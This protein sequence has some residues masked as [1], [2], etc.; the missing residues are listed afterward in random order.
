M[1]TNLTQLLRQIAIRI[2]H[3]Y[4]LK[5]PFLSAVLGCMCLIS[6]VYALDISILKIE[7]PKPSYTIL[8]NSNGA[9]GQMDPVT[10]LCGESYTIPTIYDSENLN[11]PYFV[12]PGYHFTPDS[13]ELGGDY[14]WWQYDLNM[15][16]RGI[17]H[18][19]DAI[20]EEDLAV[21]DDF[22]V[23]YAH[24]IPNKYTV[25]YN[26]NIPTLNV[27]T[28]DET[29]S[30]YTATYGEPFNLSEQVYIQPYMYQIGWSTQALGGIGADFYSL[31]AQCVNLTQ[32][33]DAKVPLYAQ[34]MPKKTLVLYRANSGTG[35]EMP[36]NTYS[37]TSEGLTLAANT[38][39]RQGYKF[40]GWDTN[41]Y[42]DSP[43]YTL[44]N[45]VISIDTLQNLVKN[46]NESW[47]EFYAIWAPI[48]YTIIFNNGEK[49]TTGDLPQNIS[50]TYDKSFTLP[51]KGEDLLCSGY[52][53]EGWSRN[54]DGSNPYLPHATLF[55]LTD[56]DNNTIT[57]YPSWKPI[58]YCVSFSPNL[59][60]GSMA[61]T[62]PYLYDKEYN[63]PPVD[64]SYK[65]EGFSFTGWSLNQ[66]AVA[67]DYEDGATV[68]NLT[69]K[70]Y[71]VATLYA[72]W[73]VKE[74]T[75]T[76]VN[77]NGD[78]N[79]GISM[80]TQKVV[81]N[82]YTSL[83]K[84]LFSKTGYRFNGWGLNSDLNGI[85]K[86]DDQEY[87]THVEQDT[88]LYTRWLVNIYSVNYLLASADEDEGQSQMEE[89]YFYYNQPE[90]LHPCTYTKVGHHF[91]HWEYTR[92]DGT[93]KTYSTETLFDAPP[94]GHMDEINVFA[95]W[96]PNDYT[97]RFSPGDD[98][99]G[100]EPSGNMPRM[101]YYYGQT[102]ED[103]S[104]V[105][106]PPI[107]F[108]PQDG[109]VFEGWRDSKN[110]NAPLLA[111][112]ADASAFIV[113]TN[114]IIDLEAQWRPITYT[115]Q[116]DAN[117]GESVSPFPES[118][119]ATYDSSSTLP[120]SPYSEPKTSGK[121]GYAFGGWCQSSNGTGEI[122]DA[123]EIGTFN[124]TTT[125]SAT[126]TLYVHWIPNVYTVIYDR[127][128]GSGS[129]MPNQS[130]TY[131]KPDTLHANSYTKLGYSF[132]GWECR[133]DPANPITYQDQAPV[134]NLT[135]E[136]EGEVT[137]YATWTPIHFLIR[138]DTNGGVGFRDDVKVDYDTEHSVE[139]NLFTFENHHFM[140]VWYCPGNGLNYSV[141]T[142]IRN[143]TSIMQPSGEPKVFILKAQWQGNVYNVYF[144]PGE[145]GQ[146][147]MSLQAFTYNISQKLKPS[148]FVRTGYHQ[149]SMKAWLSNA[150]ETYGNEQEVL[151][152]PRDPNDI[153]R[154]TL[155]A[156][157]SPNTFTIRFVSNGA[158][159]G[160]MLDMTSLIYGDEETTL[161][162]NAFTK[163]HSRFSGWSLAGG[164]IISDEALIADVYNKL[165]PKHNDTITLTAIWS[166]S[167]YEV[168]FDKNDSVNYPV[169]G[170]NMKNQG[171]TYGIVQ[172]LT[173][174]LYKRTGFTF[175]NWKDSNDTSYAD[176]VSVSN[177]ADTD[178]AIVAFKAQWRAHTY[179]VLFD[180]ARP[181]N[182][183]DDIDRSQ[184]F[185]YDDV[186]PKELT[187]YPISC[188]GFDFNQ[189]ENVTEGDGRGT[190]Y[191]NAQSITKHLSTKDNAT[192]T[193]KAHW[194]PK[195]YIIRFDSNNKVAT[196]TMRDQNFVYNYTSTLPPN[197]YTLTDHDFAGWSTQS[198]DITFRYVD[199]QLIHPLITDESMVDPNV[200]MLY[201]IWKRS[202]CTV[203]FHP[204]GGIFAQ[205][206]DVSGI[207]RFSA[208][209]DRLPVITRTGYTF[210][211]WR[212]SYRQ[213]EG[214]QSA[215]KN[216]E[217]LSDRD[218]TLYATWQSTSFP[219][220]TEFPY[221]S[222][223]ILDDD[224]NPWASWL[225]ESLTS[226][227]ESSRT[228]D[229]YSGQ[230]QP[231]NLYLPDRIEDDP[232]EKLADYSFYSSD[233]PHYMINT[234]EHIT[235]PLFTRSI[236]EQTFA[237]N[238]KLKTITF[239]EL[240]DYANGI[241]G[242]LEIGEKAFAANRALTTVTFP[243]GLIS[244]G[245]EAFRECT[246]LK[247]IYFSGS[248]P[249]FGSNVFANIISDIT[250]YYPQ[251]QYTGYYDWMIHTEDTGRF[252]L[253]SW[254]P[255][256]PSMGS[257]MKAPSQISI[258]NLLHME[259]PPST[260]DTCTQSNAFEVSLLLTLD[261]STSNTW[262]E[263]QCQ[264]N[265]QDSDIRIA[266]KSSLDQSLSWTYM[267]PQSISYIPEQGVLLV[268]VSLPKEQSGF[269][270][271]TIR[272][273][274]EDGEIEK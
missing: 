259:S 230:K 59:G 61:A 20:V 192:V 28:L 209:Y 104:S 36:S 76:F 223:S 31:N 120:S 45:Q 188:T 140:D 151:N 108:I 221:G 94:T 242:T 271:V 3:T 205:A 98:T 64:P 159:N 43:I 40:M 183:P 50:C 200:I 4:R 51:A 93:V 88:S 273:E 133:N 95:V 263:T 124:F 212:S 208:G 196:G 109:Y 239:T 24:W 26:S 70:L 130:F 180:S 101:N 253:K 198:T 68:K 141:G 46:Q 34:W 246:A 73:Q 112:Q 248:V 203:T 25:E 80:P 17:L 254:N 182:K 71:G 167:T 216:G 74:V 78:T 231:Q 54:S 47:L 21:E 201:T 29:I 144:D 165:T 187:S 117:G 267:T 269:L 131:D 265:P 79:S 186:M 219:G 191:D 35:N 163:T 49:S 161:S 235:T 207:Y 7:M 228:I 206:S 156:Q 243:R 53:F 99:S 100:R 173:P 96:T 213:V 18:R 122:Y 42:A 264:Q 153:D 214:T 84:N 91:I 38:Y 226:W 9:S 6:H 184:N 225:K 58:T 164:S 266:Y 147:S 132:N 149:D 245:D 125:Q 222:N 90:L 220:I 75:L 148:S 39:T 135:A 67:S 137:L 69:V 110:P 229:I 2:R 193:L 66:N 172:A 145:D 136:D 86:Y 14:G 41:P 150:L 138:Y 171:F 217:L 119:S 115:I 12:N 77:S 268:I 218:H 72:V 249:T 55:N 179:T 37:H 82:E 258:I 176:N 170:D 250:V 139:G 27:S 155:T 10:V 81:Y 142:P 121:L 157:W 202:E 126:V 134:S 234:F 204:Q 107:A 11:Q 233:Q 160:T 123:G 15:G 257:S 22:V 32:E 211:G 238:Y 8:F 85:V 260:L 63:L 105:K 210:T 65:R 127:G 16:E 241:D 62:E 162:P 236:G 57:F 146:G 190:F 237:Y 33:K 174:N 168:R 197:T 261:G 1:F 113:S 83:S 13:S 118:I 103:G 114:S 56:I 251:G 92:L 195:E 154:V 185:S 48:E 44:A 128:S 256:N 129:S 194:T 5:V 227:T 215:I 143:L 199:E 178:G 60:I 175:I 270:K 252:T 158:D 262:I 232:I 111:D 247:A 274:H 177:L 19:P 181:D 189:W 166:P 255:S 30:S 102:N 224:G 52:F 240:F 169:H 244:I 272:N 116:F 23:L 89:G 87:V 97:I 152:P 106:L